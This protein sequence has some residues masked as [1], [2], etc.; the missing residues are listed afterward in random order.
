QQ[1]RPKLFLLRRAPLLT[2]RPLSLQPQH[3][4]LF[5]SKMADLQ[6]SD[7]AKEKEA[8][9]EAQRLEKLAKFEAKKKAQEDA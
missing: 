6:K 1:K 7:K 8:Q 9:K 3:H 4:R 5:Y 2:L